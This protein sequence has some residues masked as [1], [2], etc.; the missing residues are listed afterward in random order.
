MSAL[1]IGLTIVGVAVWSYLLFWAWKF[2]RMVAKMK[3]QAERLEAMIDEEQAA[4]APQHPRVVELKLAETLW[5]DD[6]GQRFGVVLRMLT[7][8][9]LAHF[10]AT[11]HFEDGTH[12]AV[13][14]GEQIATGLEN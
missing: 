14:H 2:G 3:G 4:T 5:A 10:S 13:E 12:T 8:P 11:F 7:D 6:Q 9:R 1:S